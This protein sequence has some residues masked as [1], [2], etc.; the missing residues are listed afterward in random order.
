MKRMISSSYN[1]KRITYN[2][3]RRHAF[4]YHVVPPEHGRTLAPKKREPSP[5]CKILPADRV[6]FERQIE[7]LGAFAAI[8]E[9]NEHRSVSNEAV[10][11]VLTPA[12]APAT[13]LTTNAFFTDIGVLARADGGG[14]N[15]SQE[16]LDYHKAR[17]WDG[18]GA[19]EKLRPI[20]ER[21]WFYRCLAPKLHLAPQKKTLA[22]LF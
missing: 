22:L 5:L 1:V 11:S 15:P 7:I 14:F 6:V 17:K 20:F 9:T 19:K 16:L 21:T 18:I 4:F 8:H 13:V 2:P 3:L 10:G 12:L